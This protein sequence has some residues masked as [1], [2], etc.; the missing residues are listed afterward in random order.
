MTIASILH[1]AA[2]TLEAQGYYYRRPNAFFFCPERQQYVY[3]FG[4]PDR[5][6]ALRDMPISEDGLFIFEG[7]S[8]VAV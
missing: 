6:S 5:A 8:M 2:S 3:T 7:F 4:Y 1:Q